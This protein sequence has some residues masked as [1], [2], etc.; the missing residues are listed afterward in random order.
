V[1]AQ[2]SKAVSAQYLAEVLE[3]R[4]KPDGTLEDGS[5]LSEHLPDYLVAAL[6]YAT[7]SGD[8]APATPSGDA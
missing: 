2:A 4:V 1:T 6:R 3:T 8:P 5:T 7:R